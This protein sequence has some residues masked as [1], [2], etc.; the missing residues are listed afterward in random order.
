V[1][2]CATVWC[3]VAR[4]PRRAVREACIWVQLYLSGPGHTACA[5]IRDFSG[6]ALLCLPLFHDE[7]GHLQVSFRQKLNDFPSG[8]SIEDV[9]GEDRGARRED[10]GPREDGSVTEGDSSC[11]G[12]ETAARGGIVASLEKALA[13]LVATHEGT[14]AAQKGTIQAAQEER[15]AAQNR[16]IAAQGRYRCVRRAG[17]TR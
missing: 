7:R 11:P 10:Q 1:I 15:I 4:Q 5:Q 13:E 14:I 2:C 9:R 17:P 8:L 16:S 12:Q 3:L 6:K